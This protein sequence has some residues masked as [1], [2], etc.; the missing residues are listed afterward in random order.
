VLDVAGKA[1]AIDAVTLDAELYGE[2][3]KALEITTL[4]YT[5]EQKE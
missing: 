2:P 4:T 5:A 1:F 3:L